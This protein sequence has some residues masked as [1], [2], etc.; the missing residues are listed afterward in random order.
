MRCITSS[1]PKALTV[2]KQQVSSMSCV[3]IREGPGLS[4]EGTLQRSDPG[5]GAAG[6]LKRE[7]HSQR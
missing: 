5:L 3:E 7:G 6:T 4:S 1:A 2:Y